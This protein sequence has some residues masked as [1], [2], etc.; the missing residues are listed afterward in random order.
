MSLF[1]RRVAEGRTVI[2]A[3]VDYGPRQGD[4][5]VEIHMIGEIPKTKR[6]TDRRICAV[7]RPVFDRLE[8]SD[9]APPGVDRDSD[10]VAFKCDE[11]DPECWKFSE[12][13]SA[14][15]DEITS[16]SESTARHRQSGA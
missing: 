15:L 3:M 10:I 12:W 9:A 6:N 5:G 1:C 8:R 11:R 13:R 4:G 14:A 7:V 2:K 16:I